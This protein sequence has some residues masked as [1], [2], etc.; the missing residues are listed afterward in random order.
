MKLKFRDKLKFL[1]GNKLW[2]KEKKL[3]S[4]PG[5]DF[6]SATDRNEHVDSCWVAEEIN[7]QAQITQIT[8]KHYIEC[9]IE[10]SESTKGLYLF[11]TKGIFYKNEEEP[12]KEI[13][14]KKGCEKCIF[15]SKISIILFIMEDGEDII[16]DMLSGRIIEKIKAKISCINGSRISRFGDSSYIDTETEILE[17]IVAEQNNNSSYYYINENG[18]IY[19]RKYFFKAKEAFLIY[20]PVIAVDEDGNKVAATLLGTHEMKIMEADGLQNIQKLNKEYFA[21]HYEAGSDTII[22]RNGKEKGFYKIGIVPSGEITLIKEI[23]NALI[24]KVKNEESVVC[25]I[26][27]NNNVQSKE[28]TGAKDLRLSPQIGFDEGVVMKYKLVATYEKEV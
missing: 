5:L 25:T 22:V 28:Y 13:F 6:Y 26:I 2:L 9:Y 23:E 10:R 15:Y 4:W 12:L 19:H 3:V 1:W 21:L 17:I 14:S 11:G 24:C 27:S 8:K 7:G 16:A 18:I 20:E